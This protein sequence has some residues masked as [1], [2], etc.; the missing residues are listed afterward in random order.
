MLAATMPTKKAATHS[1]VSM[2]RSMVLRGGRDGGLP[3]FSSLLWTR[4]DWA[5]A[6][7]ARVG[8]RPSY[9]T[10]ANVCIQRSS[11]ALCPGSS[12]QLAPERGDGWIPGILGTSPR[13][14]NP[15]MTTASIGRIV[16]GKRGREVLQDCVRVTA[17]LAH[18]AAPGLHHGL[19]RLLP[20]GQLRVRDGVHL[21]AGLVGEL[22]NAGALEIGPGG[23]NAQRPLVGA[24]IVD[25]PLL[26]RRHSLVGRLVHD[27][28]EA[29]RVERH[30]HMVL[31]DL[32]DAE[33][34]DR[35]PRESD[36]VGHAL[37][38]DVAHLGGRGL[39]VGAA[40]LG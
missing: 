23:G 21:V 8:S 3:D 40:E 6:A 20:F 2:K 22:G 29:R 38:D 4:S 27:P 7:Q 30:V 35:A 26:R 5:M 15:G 28:H 32:V 24:M 34:R 1:M 31:G 39:H 10:D 18:A 25:H 33:Q 16:L 9:W 13:A 36:R 14:G 17:D 11:R 12:M 19:R 37:L